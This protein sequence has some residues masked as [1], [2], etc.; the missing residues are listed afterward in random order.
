MILLWNILKIIGIILLC[1]LGFLLLTVGLVLFVPIRYRLKVK[2][3]ADDT[4]VVRA[5]AKVTWLLHFISASFCYPEQ[6]YLKVK[7]L[8]ISVFS[9]EDKITETTDKVPDQGEYTLKEKN[10][11]ETARTQKAS[12]EKSGK[13]PDTKQD[14]EESLEKKLKEDTETPSVVKFFR[15]LW[16]KLKNIKY[17]IL[18]ICDKIKHV[19]KN[20]RYYLAVIQSICFQRAFSVCKTEF[21]SLF[22]CI[23]PRE[24]V[25]NFTIGTGDP[26]STAQVLAIH[27]MLYPL[28]GNHIHITPDFENIIMEGNLFVKGKITIFKVLKIA[29][30][31]YFNKDLRKVIRLLKREAA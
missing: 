22:K 23:F 8:G 24:I 10:G 29:M 1:T 15:K 16:K 9:T 26:A 21:F 25:G 5:D 17:T 3:K 18:K 13:Q 20:V 2:R 27:G 6:V 30:K 31:V 4:E 19:V 14:L 12:E 7:V 28:I 11:D